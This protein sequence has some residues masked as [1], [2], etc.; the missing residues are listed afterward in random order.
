MGAYGVQGMKRESPAAERN[1]EPILQVLLEHLPPRF[2]AS[3]EAPA[4]Q[5]AAVGDITP[6]S[7]AAL[8]AVVLEVASGS[9]QHAAHFAPELRNRGYDIQPS[10][11]TPELFDSIVAYCHD[12]PNVRLPPLQLDMAAEAWPQRVAQALQ[13]QGQ[14]ADPHGVAAVVCINMCHISP[15]EATHGLLRGAG[16]RRNW[17]HGISAWVRGGGAAHASP[18]THPTRH[19]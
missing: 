19:D 10:D 14:A 7:S 16:A 13:Q 18:L 1:K 15:V 3:G 5:A 8:P 12:Q 6:Q 11:L 2:P 17:G 4:A 9:G